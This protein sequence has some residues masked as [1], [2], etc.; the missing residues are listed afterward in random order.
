M[1]KEEL[2]ISA[3]CLHAG[4]SFGS[5]VELVQGNKDMGR[6]KMDKRFKV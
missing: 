4:G 1:R 5:V 6:G 2:L 3:I